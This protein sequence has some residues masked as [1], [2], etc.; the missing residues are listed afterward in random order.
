LRHGSN[1]PDYTN[2]RPLCMRSPLA[3]VDTDNPVH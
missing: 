1:K 3:D 2:G